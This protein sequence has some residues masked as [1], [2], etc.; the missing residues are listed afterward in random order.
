MTRERGRGLGWQ[1]ERRQGRGIKH[2][3]QHQHP[4]PPSGSGEHASGFSHDNQQEAVND[5]QGEGTGSTD[6]AQ[7]SRCKVP[8]S[9]PLSTLVQKGTSSVHGPFPASKSKLSKSNYFC[10]KHQADILGR[11][12]SW[13]PCRD[14]TRFVVG[15]WQTLIMI[16]KWD[17]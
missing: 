15:F 3:H 14:I 11:A 6:L 17:T 7:L 13:K 4:Q 8:L 10:M 2:R 1:R 9:F 12:V 5:D 16:A